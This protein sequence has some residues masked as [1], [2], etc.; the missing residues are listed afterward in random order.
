MGSK[1]E[2]MGGQPN[3]TI[4]DTPLA[5]PNHSNQ[6]DYNSTFQISGKRFEIGKKNALL[7]C[8]VMP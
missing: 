5:L 6:R 2:H 8:G 7:G 3:G 4:P 1:Q